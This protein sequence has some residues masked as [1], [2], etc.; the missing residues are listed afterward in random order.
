[1]GI[2]RFLQALHAGLEVTDGIASQT[3]LGSPVENGENGESGEQNQQEY[4]GLGQSS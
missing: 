1:M 3:R 4:R 2:E